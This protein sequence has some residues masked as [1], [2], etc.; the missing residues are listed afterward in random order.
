MVGAATPAFRLSP[1]LGAL[2]TL[3]PAQISVGLETWESSG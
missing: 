2:A 3:L 1:E